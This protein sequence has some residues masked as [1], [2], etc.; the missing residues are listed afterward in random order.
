[1]DC[2]DEEE[3]DEEGNDYNIY[4]PAKYEVEN[5]LLG[6]KR[7]IILKLTTPMNG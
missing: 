2:E 7:N 5:G 1:M 4:K 6:L 3:I